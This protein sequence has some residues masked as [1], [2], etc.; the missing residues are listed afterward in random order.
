MSLE[1]RVS[2]FPRGCES[3]KEREVCSR[4]ESMAL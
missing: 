3:K 2:S 1:K 4:E